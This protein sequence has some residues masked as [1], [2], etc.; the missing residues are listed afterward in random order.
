MAKL[1]EEA[2]N[3]IAELRPA[4]IATTSKD[5]MP[6]VAPKG[7]FR[8]ADDE[9]VIFGEMGQRHTL[10]NLRENPQVSAIVLDAVNRKG[11]RIWGKAEV[12]DSGD[13]L[14]AMAAE[15]AAR[16]VKIPYLVKV[17]VEEVVTF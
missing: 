7:S 1:T 6:N 16:G 5:G 11:C 13:L 8:V 3:L 17:T 15:F 4:F 9:H 2:K 10:A 12:L 14:E